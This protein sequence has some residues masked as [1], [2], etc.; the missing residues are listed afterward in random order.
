M[1]YVQ[2]QGV[3]LTSLPFIIKAL[4]VALAAHPHIN[5][6]LSPS[7]SELALHRAHNIGIAMATPLG[8]V[9]PNIKQVGLGGHRR[10]GP[11][12]G[13]GGAHWRL[14][15][16]ARREGVRGA[17]GAAGCDAEEHMPPL[18]GIVSVPAA[19]C[20][21]PCTLGWGRLTTHTKPASL[22]LLLPPP[23]LHP[24]HTHPSPMQ[25]QEKSIAHI[26]REL[27]LLQQLA[28]AGKLPTEALSGGTISISNIGR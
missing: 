6:S 19:V 15:V 25:V 24:T 12:D 10:A 4:S 13:G 17:V 14:A 20:G 9:V 7:G 28:A 27:A 18:P 21:P 1:G 26:S 16:G 5:A 23:P 8:L 2:A 3:K 11:G 22:A